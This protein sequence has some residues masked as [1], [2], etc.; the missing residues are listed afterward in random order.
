MAMAAWVRLMSALALCCVGAGLPVP[1]RSHAQIPPRVPRLSASV[2]GRGVSGWHRGMWPKPVRNSVRLS[3]DSVEIGARAQRRAAKRQR[4]RRFLAGA[5][6]A[7]SVAACAWPLLRLCSGT[8]LK[9]GLRSGIAGWRSYVG[10]RSSD[11][12]FLLFATAVVHPVMSV[13]RMSPVLGFLFAGM[14]IGPNGLGWI[15]DIH[16]INKLA[17]FGV[18]FFLFE[19]G[20]ELEL[21][22]LKSVGRDAFTLGTVQMLLTSVIIGAAV[23]GLGASPSTALVLGGGLALSSSAFVIQLLNE[24][25]EL[26]SRFGRAS[27]GILLLQDLAVVPLLMV[28]PLL[29]GSQAQLGAALRLAAIKSVSALAIIFVVGRV[30]LYRAYKLI[31]SAKDQTS[32]LAITLGTV[33]SMAGFTE[34]L[35][36]SETLG[37][38]LAGVLLAETKYRFQIEADIAP[39]RGLLLGLFFMTTGFAID[40]KF[41]L[42]SWRRVIGSAI[43]IHT[44]KTAVTFLVCLIVGRLKRT[45]ALRSALLLSQGGEFAFVLF[46][47]ALQHGILFPGQAKLLL[48][49][50]V[51][52]MFLTP[53][54]N[55]LGVKMSSALERSNEMSMPSPLESEKSS[56][57]LLCGFGTVGRSVADLMTAK[58]VRYKAFDLNPYRV[59]ECRQL[60]LP[61]FFG[62]ARRTEVLQT[63]VEASQGSKETISSVVVTMDDERSC[64]TAARAL[65]RM[66]PDLPIFVRAH[67]QKH[68]RKLMA[69]GATAVETGQEES[70]LILGGALL[71]SMGMPMKEVV[72][73][74]DETRSSMYST[75]MRD[76]FDSRGP[77]SSGLQPSGASSKRIAEP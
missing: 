48:T 5:V 17:G 23:M 13:F 3:Q 47:L 68:R 58:L 65:R 40:I 70:A 30:V 41:A 76:I 15:T 46:G 35:G 36:L 62:D 74:I 32:F 21:E 10:A 66:Y 59:S 42:S 71:S 57:V 27:F 72:S 12:I 8:L 31:A 19:M 44:V 69:T 77:K 53:F 1:Q 51:I 18:V 14:A 33:L 60:G 38:F 64:T 55:E 28:T 49:T 7:I 43:A 24:K 67:G 73:L 56:F 20:L 75:R 37:A 26:A 11:T 22:R 39:F 61:V 34:A 4:Q 25:G 50:V 2:P 52:T 54:L 16:S 63:F 45:D 9:S 6:A 29:A